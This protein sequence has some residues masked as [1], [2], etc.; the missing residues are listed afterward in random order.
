MTAS[1][2]NRNDDHVDTDKNDDF[3]D[4][5]G[6]YHEHETMT[7]INANIIDNVFEWLWHEY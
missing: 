1:M 6:S 4:Y 7:T 3:H 2:T 5:L